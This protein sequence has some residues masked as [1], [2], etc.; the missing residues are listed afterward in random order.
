MTIWSRLLK[1]RMT[2]YKKYKTFIKIIWIK[3]YS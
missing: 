2:T 3:E 1:K